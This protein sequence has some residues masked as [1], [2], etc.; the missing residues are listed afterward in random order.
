[1]T[2][3]KGEG[4]PAKPRPDFPL[5]PHPC[6]QWVKRIHGKLWHFGPWRDPEGAL[7]EY[8]RQ[9][10][11]I[12][13][14]GEAS[15][16][17]LTVARLCDHFLHSRKQLLERGDLAAKTWNDYLVEAKALAAFFGPARTVESLTPRDF[18]RYRESFP[19]TWG[20]VRTNN[21]IVRVNAIINYAWKEGHVK[22]PIQTG[23]A[24]RRVSQK[25]L[26]IE[27]SAKPVKFFEAAEVRAMLDIA[28]TQMRAMILLGINAG[29][30]NA[31]CARLTRDM[32][33]GGWL[34]SH[35]H[36]TG[37][38]RAA[39]L[40]P[41]TIEAIDTVVAKSR[42]QVPAEYADLVFLTR[43]R[44]PWW[45]DGKS[46]DAITGQ[47]TKLR[48]AAGVFRKGVGF[49]SLRHVT[50]TI[51]EQAAVRDG[52]AIKILM[53][54]VDSSISAEYRENYDREPIRI[55]CEHLRSWLFSDAEKAKIENP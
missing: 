51:G 44:K 13:G 23:V 33:A 32:I 50:Q 7:A 18:A 49:Y 22:T 14:G 11:A 52:V 46:G 19:K 55:I 45:V 3:P 48:T 54:H 39:K 5:S 16:G 4:K 30:G 10:D 37:I 15:G 36:K 38:W 35:R 17:S 2:R 6:G 20:A 53:G 8:R 29:Y 40:W 1:M 27:R 43:H 47:F 12:T 41:E 31:D 26:R 42:K 25:R 34:E 21:A 9:R 24:F 28:S